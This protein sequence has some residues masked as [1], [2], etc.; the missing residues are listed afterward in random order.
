MNWGV[1][2]LLTLITIVVATVSVG[3]YMVSQDTDSLE[4]EGYY[5]KG[6]NYESVIAHK[7]NVEANDVQPTITVKNNYIEFQFKEGNNEGEI[8]LKRASNQKLDKVVPFKSNGLKYT[9][10]LKDFEKGAW[11]I[12]I[13]WTSNKVSY[14][15]EKRIFRP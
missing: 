5:E 4:E 7:R 13:N 12:Q 1:K 10:S 9:L 6:L 3:I 15:Y 8:F 14:Y 2:I 11:E